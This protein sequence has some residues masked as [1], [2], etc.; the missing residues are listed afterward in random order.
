M[1]ITEDFKESYILQTFVQKYE[2]A[3]TELQRQIRKNKDRWW[4]P[5]VEAIQLFADRNNS[6]HFYA[7]LKEVY[8][9][10]RLA[11]VKRA[12]GENL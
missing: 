3:K 5:K 2:A 1:K 12:D 6:K 10:Q 4:L 9:P 11:P 8:G 7:S